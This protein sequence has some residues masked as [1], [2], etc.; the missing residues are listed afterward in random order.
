MLCLAISPILIS[1]S[2]ENEIRDGK[3]AGGGKGSIFIWPR[4]QYVT[5]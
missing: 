3:G 2:E 4:F 1:C 5:L